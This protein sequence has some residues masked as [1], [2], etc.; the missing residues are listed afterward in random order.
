M[1]LE[2]ELATYKR[3]LHQLRGDEGK[4]A[5]IHDQDLIG[6]FGTYE[7]ALN[8]GYKQFGLEVFLVK[9]IEACEQVQFVSR[10]F[11]QPCHT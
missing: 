9:K 8:E 3:V 6:V 7:D 2:T 1:A 5:L 10:L 11:D 4:F